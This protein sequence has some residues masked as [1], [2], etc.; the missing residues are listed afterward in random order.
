MKLSA[1]ERHIFAKLR[2]MS[3]SYEWLCKPCMEDETDLFQ[4]QAECGEFNEYQMRH[5]RKRLF[6]HIEMFGFEILGN[7]C[8]AI[9]LRHPEVQGKVFKWNPTND[10]N[11]FGFVTQMVHI[12][13]SRLPS[14]YMVEGGLDGYIAIVEEL[15]ENAGWSEDSIKEDDGGDAWRDTQRTLKRMGF[16][17][18]D[19]HSGNI[20]MR[21]SDVN[22]W[23]LS[24]PT[25]RHVN[26]Y[27]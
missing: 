20:M 2:S 13:H 7:G 11:T 5:E 6:R 12:R 24:D 16:V 23:V 14:Y 15:D 26:Q 19:I 25:T 18:N 9:V 27:D 10:D 22:A 4:M 21:G 1:I 3:K 8:F 17:A